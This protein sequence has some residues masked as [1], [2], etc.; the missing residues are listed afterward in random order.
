MV[1][2]SRVLEIFKKELDVEGLS[3]L[4]FAIKMGLSYSSYRG[5]TKSSAKKVP[6]WVLGYL[7]G[8]GY[9][10]EGGRLM[11]VKKKSNATHYVC[12]ECELAKMDA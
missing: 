11:S 6:R 1:R 9:R 5:V 8:R 10:V 4:D 12:V 3:G 7:E 2:A